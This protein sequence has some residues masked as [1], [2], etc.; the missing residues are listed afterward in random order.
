MKKASPLLAFSLVVLLGFLGP[1]ACGSFKRFL[2]EGP[3]RDEWQQPDRVVST[4]AL[5]PGDDVAD[6]GSGG[7]Y[8]TYRFAEAVGDRGRVYALDVDESLLSY[9]AGQAKKRELTQITTVHTPEDG[10]GIPDESV[11]LIFLSNVYHHLPN[12]TE[13]FRRAGTALRSGGRLA[14]VEFDGNSF[15]KSHATAPEEIQAQLE[16]AGYELAEKHD[17]LEKQSFQIFVRSSG[18]GG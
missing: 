18:M 11:D 3:G 12:P 14:V 17:F 6:L 5:S 2:Y 16:A 10:L 8:F 13:Y 7:G 15:L 4:L 9:I 1:V